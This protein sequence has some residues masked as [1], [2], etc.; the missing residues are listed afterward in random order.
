VPSATLIEKCCLVACPVAG[1][2]TQYMVEQAFALNGLDW[3]FMTFEVEPPRLGDAMRGIRALGFHGVKI[4]EPF[5]ETVIE[6]LDG[7]DPSQMRL[8][9][10]NHRGRPARRRFPGRPSSNSSGSTE[11]L[12]A[13]ARW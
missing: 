11:R 12:S 8:G 1:N 10:H 6:R 4:D 7:L 2:P 5:Q 3:R 13:N 9:K